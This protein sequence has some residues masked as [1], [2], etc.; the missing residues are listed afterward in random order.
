VWLHTNSRSRV[1][2]WCG[3]RRLVTVPRSVT[4]SL[5]QNAM[6]RAALL[7]V[8]SIVVLFLVYRCLRDGVVVSRGLRVERATSPLLYWLLIVL[9]VLLS[10]VLFWAALSSASQR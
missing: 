9:F 5:Q 3:R 2:S 8:G 1:Y 10:G 7:I 4:I 6:A